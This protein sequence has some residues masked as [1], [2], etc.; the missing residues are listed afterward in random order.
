MSAGSEGEAR[1]GRRIVA[2][3]GCLLLRIA[4]PVGSPIKT[5][6]AQELGGRDTIVLLRNLGLGKTI[7]ISTNNHFSCTFGGMVYKCKDPSSR[8]LKNRL[9]PLV[10]AIPALSVTSSSVLLPSPVPSLLP[11]FLSFHGSAFFEIKCIILPFVVAARRLF[12]AKMCH[13]S[14]LSFA[15][16]CTVLSSKRLCKNG[17]PAAEAEAVAGE[18]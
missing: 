8:P 18:H 15:L 16:F 12:I 11:F 17:V 7:S 13:I 14:L 2:V 1:I 6:C 4:S 10:A 3:V 9:C 5:T